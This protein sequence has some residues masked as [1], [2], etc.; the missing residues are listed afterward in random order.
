MQRNKQSVILLLS[1]LTLGMGSLAQADEK[2]KFDFGKREYIN[3]CAACHGVTGKAEGTVL[4]FLKRTPPDLTALSKNNGGVFPFERIYAVIDGRQAV[5]GH[6]SRD[7]P[8]WGKDLSTE[9]VKA[10]EYFG[11]M[12]YNMEMYVRSRILTLID[13]LHRI[14][15]K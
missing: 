15:K 8:V 13:Y 14:Q 11:P 5:Q 9:S 2:D 10:D 12:P 1:L 6:G 7:M 4:D 3:R